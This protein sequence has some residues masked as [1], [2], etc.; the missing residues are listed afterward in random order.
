[1]KIKV[2]A[3]ASALLIAAPSFAEV[4]AIKATFSAGGYKKNTGKVVVKA[5]ATGS[6]FTNDTV[7]IQYAAGQKGPWKNISP[8]TRTLSDTGT[9]SFSFTNSAKYGCFR[10]LTAQNGNDAADVVSN[11]VCEK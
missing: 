1:M 7:Q 4:T 10:V 6:D 8:R 5:A 9:T 3:L 2:I 11:K